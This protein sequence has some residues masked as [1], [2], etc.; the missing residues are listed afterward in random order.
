[1]FLILLGRHVLYSTVG[2]QTLPFLHVVAATQSVQK[3]SNKC[4]VKSIVELKS[5]AKMISRYFSL[6]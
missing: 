1:M 3:I 5:S 6:D 2:M 4:T